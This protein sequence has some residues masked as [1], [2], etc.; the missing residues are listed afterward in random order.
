MRK[1]EE[2]MRSNLHVL[3]TALTVTFGLAAANTAYAQQPNIQTCQPGFDD[4]FNGPHN[5]RYAALVNSL[6]TNPVVPSAQLKADLDAVID[7]TTGDSVT[8]YAALLADAQALAGSLATGRIMITL[9]DGTVVVDTSR[10]NNSFANYKAKAINENHNSRIAFEVAQH[11]QCGM[12]L[13]TKRSSS[14]GSV[15]A[16]FAMRLGPHLDSSGTARMSTT[17]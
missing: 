4:A 14:T 6:Q 13:E 10:T 3:V 16:Y 5:A 8:D 1:K 7:E 11:Y 9:P 2:L 12:G 15:E 17:Q